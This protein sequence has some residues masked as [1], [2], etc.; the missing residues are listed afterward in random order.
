MASTLL[1]LVVMTVSSA[2][3]TSTTIPLSAAATVNGVTFL[4]FSAAGATGGQQV[5]YSILDTGNSEIGT[6]TYTSSNT[7]LTSRTP[8]QSTNGGA[9]ITASSASLIYAT[10]RGEDLNSF[11]VAGQLLGTSTNDDASAGNVGEYI[12]HNNNVN[13]A[14]STVTTISSIAL[15]AGD[16]DVTLGFAISGSGNPTS[17]DIWA[18][19]DTSSNTMTNTPGLSYRLRGVTISDPVF[20]ASAGPYRVTV[21]SSASPQTYYGNARVV[22]TPGVSMNVNMTLRAR[23]ER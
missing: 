14:S 7:T 21:A 19:I 17:S 6:A 16:W 3:G 20:S 4:S 9:A 12:S 8:T 23:R 18:S 11:I 15:T 1:D 2:F 5:S 22:W 10:V 13:V